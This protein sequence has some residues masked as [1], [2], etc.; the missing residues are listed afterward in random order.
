MTKEIKEKIIETW[1]NTMESGYDTAFWY[2]GK[3]IN[4]NPKEAFFDRILELIEES[5]QKWFKELKLKDRI[6]LASELGKLEEKIK[7]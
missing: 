6:N 5:K 3:L 2:K 7:K 4:G 1:K